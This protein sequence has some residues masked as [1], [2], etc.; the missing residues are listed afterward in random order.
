MKRRI[1]TNKSSPSR[2]ECEEAGKISL[3]KRHRFFWKIRAGTLPRLSRNTWFVRLALALVLAPA[4]T[5]FLVLLVITLLSS[6]HRRLLRQP[7]SNESATVDRINDDLLLRS[8][9]CRLRESFLSGD[10][11]VGSHRSNV[12]PSFANVSC[13]DALAKLGEGGVRYMDLDVTLLPGSDAEVVIAHPSELPGI[14][15]LISKSPCSLVP[16]S[17]LLTL[18]VLDLQDGGWFL[19]LEPKASW[20]GSTGDYLLLPAPLEVLASLANVL[21]SHGMTPSRCA[22]ILDASLLRTHEGRSML[23]RIR[24]R[25][26]LSYPVSRRT[27]RDLANEEAVDF[28]KN[29]D[30]K[31]AMPT[32]ELLPRHSAYA[33]LREEFDVD[34]V[35]EKLHESKFREIFWIVDE[36][37]DLDTVAEKGG[38]AAP[39]FGIVSNHPLD[40]INALLFTDWC[41]G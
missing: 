14:S 40:I 12:G 32:V 35:M 20:P 41:Q 22:V 5:L 11:L 36:L 6:A 33:G 19:T 39:P 16:L 2:H 24:E 31:Y 1:A 13:A 7:E 38:S 10:F 27:A 17:D 30:Y 15:G 9:R 4:V 21:E 23:S 3:S 28:P 29:T 34:L 25:C 26:D 37:D 8:G 18:T